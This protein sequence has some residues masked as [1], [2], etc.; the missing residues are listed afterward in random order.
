MWVK[1]KDLRPR[2]QPAVATCEMRTNTREIVGSTYD[3][4]VC[5]FAA[6]GRHLWDAPVGGFVFDLAAGD[7]DGDGK[8]EAAVLPVRGQAKDIVFLE[9]P[10]FAFRKA[11]FSHQFL[12]VG[13]MIPIGG[14]NFP[15]N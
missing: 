13:I 5:A 12:F 1:T 14:I 15:I 6:S 10:A 11:R 9:V 2:L 3:N 8:D 4:R 7:L